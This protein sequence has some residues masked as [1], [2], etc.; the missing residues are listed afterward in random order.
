MAWD[1]QSGE[2]WGGTTNGDLDWKE[3]GTDEWGS[4]TD[5]WWEPR[6][7]ARSREDPSGVPWPLPQ[8]KRRQRGADGAWQWSGDFGGGNSHGSQPWIQE[9]S[10]WVEKQHG[11]ADGDK[12]DGR[13]EGDR[14]DSDWWQ[15]GNDDGDEAMDV[16][17]GWEDHDEGA[18]AA[19]WPGHQVCFHD[20]VLAPGGGCSSWEA[21]QG[22]WQSAPRFVLLFLH[23]CHHGP[24]DVLQYVPYLWDA[25]LRP[26]DVRIRAPCSPQREPH[27]Q[28]QGWS[29]NSWYDYTTD[30]CWQ[31]S[32]DR[33]EWTQFIEQR[34]RILEILEEEHSRL[35][36]GG[37]LVLG[38]LSQGVSLA[39]DV[40]LHAPSHIDSIV[41]CFCCRGMVQQETKWDLPVAKVR[42]RARSCPIFVFHGKSDATVPWPLARRSYQ[43]LSDCGFEVDTL[44]QEDIT[45]GTT[46]I[47]EYQRVADFVAR[48]FW[49]SDDASF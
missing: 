44:A 8:R 43:W 12:Y 6:R 48:R 35:P 16:D 23:S 4:S 20:L 46:S 47:Q 49:D 5:E 13:W 9:T 45:H 33:V 31:G 10:G 42:Q 34:K 2:E 28:E 25:G 36:P 32:E 7:G 30:R 15:S 19:Y 41:G 29:Q 17:S 39:L 37:R 14:R 27:C 24:E 1:D 11:S 22:W 38:G 26:S 21:S 18:E 3:R 40:M